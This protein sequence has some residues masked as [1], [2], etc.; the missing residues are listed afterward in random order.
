[1]PICNVFKKRLATPGTSGATYSAHWLR[2]AGLRDA[3]DDFLHHERVAID[4]ELDL[5]A[6]HSPF[7]KG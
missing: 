4:A 3:I 5:L 2:H 7:R 6:A 1:M